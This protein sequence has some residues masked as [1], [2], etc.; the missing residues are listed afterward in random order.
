MLNVELN[1]ALLLQSQKGSCSEQ[2]GCP[3]YHACGQVISAAFSAGECCILRAYA[4]TS[5]ELFREQM[6]V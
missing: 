5:N 6:P 1:V 4:S 2:K 3:C